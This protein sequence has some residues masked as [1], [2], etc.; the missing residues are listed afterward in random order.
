MNDENL[1][2]V[3]SGTTWMGGG[4]GSIESALYRLL[5]QAS[6]E[7]MIV[8]YTISTATP[9]L[10]QELEAALQRGIRIRCLMNRFST[11]P[12]K[13]QQ[14]F[15]DLLRSFPHLLQ[16]FSFTPTSD[17]A[18]LHA[19]AIIVDRHYALVGSANLSL[20]GLMDNHELGI[21]I[22]GAGAAEI[23]RAVDL[24]LASPYTS[25]VRL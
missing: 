4:L 11:Q 2:V 8:A 17:E 10:F 12:Y 24:L 16:V 22:T 5:T 7:I 15:R 19:K 1:R 21:V 13:V 20:R 25:S 23:A 9:L 14:R 18:D 3:V 6:D